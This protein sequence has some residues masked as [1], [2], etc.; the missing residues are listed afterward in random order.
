MYTVTCTVG[1]LGSFDEDCSLFADCMTPFDKLN[2]LPG[3]AFSTQQLPALMYTQ[4]QDIST[5]P[6]IKFEDMAA[7]AGVS[8]D[9]DTDSAATVPMPHKRARVADEDDDVSSHT[10]SPN[11]LVE[12]PRLSFTGAESSISST[13]VN[14]PSPPPAP[15]G[16]APVATPVVNSNPA[17][18]SAA[19]QTMNDSSLKAVLVS[20]VLTKSDASSK[21]IILPRIAVE[22]NLPQLTSSSV[23]NFTAQDSKGHSWP[24]CIKAWANGQNPK[25]VYVLEQ[26]GDVLKMHKLGA[27][28]AVAVL[29]TADGRFSLEWN[30]AEVRAAA[31]RP[32]CAA[33]TFQQTTPPVSTPCQP[34]AVALSPKQADS[35]T[36]APMM[37]SSSM[38]VSHGPHV[39]GAFVP[40]SP[41]EILVMGSQM[42]VAPYLQL[43]EP[44]VLLPATMPTLVASA[45]D[46][47]G[48]NQVSQLQPAAAAA[49]PLHMAGTLLCPRTAGCTRPAGHQGWCLGHKGFKKRRG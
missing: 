49:A 18:P 43:D 10:G 37:G 35:A 16:A 9:S 28:D 17:V 24:L 15:P 23:F 21:R 8:P 30:T 40:T 4:H 44:A 46:N 29:A 31:A 27:G 36:A 5:M 14:T 33:F 2:D 42:P 47:H 1:L 19:V 20:K 6:V 48:L 11:D 22:A 26:I 34:A 7:P 45:A 39:S 3:S 41:C 25:P 13:A 12:M 38:P 32:T